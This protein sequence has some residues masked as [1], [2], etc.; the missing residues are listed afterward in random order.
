M[1][2]IHLKAKNPDFH[3]VQL[4]KLVW[5]EVWCERAGARAID[6][7]DICTGSVQEDGILALLPFRT[8]DL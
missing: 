5:G 2:G 1:N 6:S 4:R 7:A 3:K 8:L